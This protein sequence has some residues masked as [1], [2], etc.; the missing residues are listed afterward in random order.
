[1]AS[2]V[3]PERWLPQIRYEVVGPSDTAQA[4]TMRRDPILIVPYDPA[5]P[6]AFAAA[7]DRIEP[8]LAPWLVRPVEH[9]GS[10]S[11][12]GLPAKPIV[13]M[14]AVVRDIGD[15]PAAV[16]G[17]EAANWVPAPEPGDEAERRLSFCSPTV[18][19]RTHHLHV[20]E[21]RLPDWPSWL[22]FRDYLRSHP[23]LAGAYAALKRELAA[24]HG[25]DPNQRDAYRQ[26]K[27]A[28]I[29]EVTF[30]ALNGP[31]NLDGS[32]A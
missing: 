29:R 20:V 18:A 7:R 12:P 26:G 6:E 3:V 4:W 19:N 24:W 22:A 10:T 23:G 31:S 30:I 27:A 11:V 15:V 21:E 5:W 9:M 32:S 8:V 17:L 28:F 25:A 16:S 13:D 1:M 2:R 14:L